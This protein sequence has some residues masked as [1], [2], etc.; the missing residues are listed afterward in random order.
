M[1]YILT[2]FLLAIVLVKGYSQS[3]GCSAA[4]V[5]AV[6]ANCSSP[7]SGT[8]TGATQTIAGCV[9]TADDDVW[10]KFTATA[11]NHMITVVP[12]ASMDPVVQL[13]SGPC[14]SLISLS[15]MD[16]GLTGET[17]TI[18]ANGLTVGNVYTI[19]IYHYYTGSGSGNFTI[20]VT[21][22]PTPPSNDY[23]TN[24]VLLNVN[25]SCSYTNSTS[26]G[27]SQSQVGCAGTADDDVWFKFIATNSV[28]TITVDP[29]VSMDAVV[30]LFSGACATLTSIT[31]MDIG[32]T[33]D[34]EVINAV[35]LIPGNTYYIRVYDY[36]ASTGGAPFQICIV[37]A[38]TP[39]PSND[40]PC[41]AIVLPQVTSSCN[42]LNFTTTGAT[43]STTSP[44]PSSCAGGSASQQGGFNNSPQPKDVWFTITVPSSGIISVCP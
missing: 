20:C 32:F 9:G 13:F 34:N 17:E 26:L 24:A 4:T 3:D 25:T 44:T 15:C 41:N 10:Y 42:F 6:T 5:V 36:Y 27:A 30:E 1:K 31:C 40:E 18:Y 22:A 14:S 19:R 43:T 21:T 2:I 7:T 37:G 38:A 28:Q 39:T 33:D 12:S 35:G 23:C 29:S 11:T 8:T 16:N